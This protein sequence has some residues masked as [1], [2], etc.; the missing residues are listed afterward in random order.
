MLTE[1]DMWDRGYRARH[2]LQGLEL[3]WRGH[4]NRLIAEKIESVGLKHKA[5]LE[6]GAGDSAWIPYLADKYGDSRFAG[7]DYS[8]TGCARLAQRLEQAGL[9]VEVFHQ[10][11]FAPGPALLGSFDLVL[12]FGLVEHFHD[13]GQ[14]LT[15]KKRFLKPHGRLF[16]LI[17]NLAGSLGLLTRLYNREVYALH[18]PHDWESFRDGHARA[19]L[20]ILAGGYLG[21]SNFGV[22][23]SCFDHPSGLAWHECYLHIFTPSVKIT[24]KPCCR[25]TRR[26]RSP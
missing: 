10:D 8:E 2:E 25:H 9:S 15:A 6:L 21:S 7:L 16:T 3:G 24:L 4:T 14:V 18:N 23:A 17:P 19:G 11:M 20:R 5:I 22:A 13:L 1:K 26:S 12:S